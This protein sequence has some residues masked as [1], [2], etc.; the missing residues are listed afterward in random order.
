MLLLVLFYYVITDLFVFF[1]LFYIRVSYICVLL[2]NDTCID[3]R[4]GTSAHIHIQ[5]ENIY[6]N[7]VVEKYNK[8]K[9]SCK[10]FEAITVF[11]TVVA[12]A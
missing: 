5:E 9:V 7:I 2:V 3:S 12:V 8:L 6:I 4:F 11:A 1:P 10:E